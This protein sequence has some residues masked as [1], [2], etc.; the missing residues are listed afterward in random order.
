VP[1][2]HD[3]GVSTA[4][5]VVEEEPLDLDRFQDMMDAILKDHAADLYRYKGV[6]AAREPNGRIERAVLQGVHDVCECEPKGPWPDGTPY[7]TQ[8]VFIGRNL[9]KDLWAK[10][11]DKCKVSH[12]TF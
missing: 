5:L 11:L 12:V 2:R 1:F 3:S 9:E 8:V 4:A 6:V 7:K 10:L